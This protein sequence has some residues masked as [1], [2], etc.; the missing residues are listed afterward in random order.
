M[1]ADRPRPED[2]PSRDDRT[3]T[4]AAV[5]GFSLALGVGTVAIPLVALDAGYAP[6][7][8]GALVAVAAATQL[9]VRLTLPWL[10]GRFP[11]RS[12]MAVAAVGL[13]GTFALLIASTTLPVFVPAQLLQGTARA[14][15]WTSSQTHAVRG[16]GSSV[17]RLVD[18]NVA[19]NLGTL[20]GPAIAG[21][22]AIVGMPLAL[23][24]AVVAGLGASILSLRLHPL[25]AFDRWRSAGTLGLLRRPGVDV[26]CW[27][28]IIGGAWWAMLGS[29]VPVL[30]VGAG[31]GPTGVGWLTTASEGAGMVALLLQRRISGRATHRAAG[32]AWRRRRRRVRS[33]ASPSVRRPRGLRLPAHRRW[34]GQRDVDDARAGAGQPGRRAAR[35][36]RRAGTVRDLPGGGAVRRAGHRQRG[37]RDPGHR[38]GAGRPVGRDPAAGVAIAARSRRGQRASGRL[39]TAR[40][41]R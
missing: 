18:M 1:T 30:L 14:M 6:A 35:A 39:R 7:A 23:S 2:S 12:L 15:F 37:G 41:R 24:A 21:T 8:V 3:P 19:G 10:L 40:A 11:D 28:G 34:G 31:F 38:A 26:A 32:G 9:G 5:V 22:L 17:R 29:F 36:G 13:A 16:P 27:A 4:L 20:S 25:E 33:R